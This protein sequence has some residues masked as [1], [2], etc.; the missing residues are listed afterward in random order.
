[1]CLVPETVSGE[2]NVLSGVDDNAEN[3]VVMYNM[4]F[5]PVVIMLCLST[6]KDSFQK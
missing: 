2:L 6:V 4:F 1:M 5:S 3:Y